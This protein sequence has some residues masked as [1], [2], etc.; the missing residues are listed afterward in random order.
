MINIHQD[1]NQIDEKKQGV[2]EEE[3]VEREGHIVKI[4]NFKFL[5]FN[6]FPMT[7]VQ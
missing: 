1:K 5:I 2:G 4:T 7:N 3:V 6:Q